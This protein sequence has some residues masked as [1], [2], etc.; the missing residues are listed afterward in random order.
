LPTGA[1][2]SPPATPTAAPAP[3]GLPPSAV[4]DAQPT[5]PQAP[6]W[7][8]AA[9]PPAA[10][11]PA[12]A[13]PAA[14]ARLAA[15]PRSADEAP[16]VSDEASP[17]RA[18]GEALAQGHDH[19]PD[20]GY[21]AA[22]DAPPTTEPLPDAPAGEAYGAEEDVDGILAMLQREGIFEPPT[23]TPAVW[24]TRKEVQRTG[25]R[26]GRTLL[27]LWVVAVVAAAGGW[28]GWTRYV[29][30]RHAESAR[31]LAQATSEASDG[32]HASLVDAERHLREA[33]D[34]NPRAVEVVSLLLFVQTQRA[35]EE[36][37]FEAGYLRPTLERARRE[38]ADAARIAAAEAVLAIADGKPD[39]ARRAIGEALAKRPD[40]AATLYVA[41]RLEQRLGDAGALEHLAAAVEKDPAL[42]TASIALAEAK[43]DDGNR[44][45]ALRLLDAVLARRND[46]LRAKLWRTF[47]AADE[48]DPDAGLAELE[49]LKVRL[50][51]GAP[52]DRV[53]AELIK[54]R[55]HRRKG[56]N[57]KAS[58]AVDAAIG[59]GATEPRLL[60]LVAIEARG[61][62]RLDRAQQAATQAAAGAPSNADF[63]KL[64]A[65]IQVARRDGVAALATLARL[66]T[67]DPAVLL[68]SARAALLVGAPDSLAAASAALD[69]FVASH[70]DSVEGRA[71]QL[72]LRVK[73]GATDQLD[74]ARRLAREAPGDPLVAVAVGEAALA[75]RDG[76]LAVQSLTTLVRAAPDDPEAHYLLG[77]A[78]RL[79]ADPDGAEQSFRRAIELGPAMQDAR[80]AL[81][82]L[83]L[84]RGKYEE[85]D[86]LY[87]ELARRAGVTA[88]QA[89][90]MLGRLGRVEALLG[91]GKVAD[92]RVQLDG[93]RAADVD[94][95]A[96]RMVRARLAL[97]ENTPGEAVAALRPLVQ[98][99]GPKGA[100]LLALYGDALYAAGEVD[101][102][103]AQY[104]AALGVDA[105]FPE[106]LLGRARVA[107]RAERGGD[108]VA[109]LERMRAALGARIRPPALR[110]RMLT[111]LG[112][113]KLL[114][115][116]DRRAPDAAREALRQATAI[117]GAP[118]EAFF[119]LGE[120]TAPVDAAAARAA[121]Q[122]YLELA[123]D[124][125]L[126]ARARQALAPR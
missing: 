118:P 68:L 12:A 87:Q 99:D 70:P 103:A 101:A 4:F 112:M 59:A 113:A 124:G 66:S 55:L 62:G 110:A 60:A 96:A 15:P 41:G 3:F 21:G 25:S 8:P 39:D 53:I 122:R 14:A 106:A 22:A 28:F 104:D 71:L 89:S 35:L 91:M 76:A 2:P 90:S 42:F 109:Y 19:D 63:R 26:I 11:P 6:K 82:G 79:A 85:A 13:P 111:T 7:T 75:A 69:A 54:S 100:E 84:D 65:E 24:A 98:G 107:V 117:D 105:G 17:P 32:D 1:A 120:A 9:A 33:R 52:T 29:E 81:G 114:D 49:A 47:L 31:L 73:Q 30:G 78:R 64:L 119:Y 23:G 121:Y 102:A 126:A 58:E 43:A 115:R 27:V 20:H 108:A 72:R 34:L 50:D 97:A 46:H 94:T 80:V 37:A 40:D 125:E 86:A 123:P 61:A 74:A 77:R 56:D 45:E 48:V 116:R 18:A 83:L 93:L 57:A 51:R 95:P 16:P 88:G 36:G 38:R 92:A 67:D 44:E 10:A 5:T